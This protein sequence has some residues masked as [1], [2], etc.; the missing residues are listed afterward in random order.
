MEHAPL[1]RLLGPGDLKQTAAGGALPHLRAIL[2]VVD[3]FG[4]AVELKSS[5][6]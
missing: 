4:E 3:P 5:S 1:V 2:E 6:D